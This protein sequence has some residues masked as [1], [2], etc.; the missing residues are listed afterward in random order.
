MPPE[1]PASTTGMSPDGAGR[2]LELGR[3]PGGRRPGPPLRPP[4]GQDLETPRSPRSVDSRS[5]SRCHRSRRTTTL[6]RVR[7]WSSAANIP[8]SSR[9]RSRRV[10]SPRATWTWVIAEPCRSSHVVSKTQQFDLAGLLHVARHDARERTVVTRDHRARHHAHHRHPRARRRRPRAP[11]RGGPLGEVSGVGEA[12]RLADD[13]PDTRS[14]IASG[15]E[16]FDPTLI[17][18]RR[19]RARDP[20]RRPRRSHRRAPALRR[21]H[22]ARPLVRRDRRA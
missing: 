19:R 3:W 1:P 14:A 20:P 13:D 22:V 11:Q 9:R 8:R 5:A 18:Q 17:Q 12:G 15:V 21:A 4:R 16:L 6:K 2:A 10:E 7:T